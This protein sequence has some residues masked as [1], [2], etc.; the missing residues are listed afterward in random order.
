MGIHPFLT[1]RRLPT[2]DPRVGPSKGEEGMNV[3]ARRQ[4]RIAGRLRTGAL[5]FGLARKALL[6]T[7]ISVA[8]M[9]FGASA[10]SA[11]TQ[12]YGFDGSA[13]GTQV[14]VGSTVQSGR[15]A[16]VTLGC[17]PTPGV[18]NT[19]TAASVDVPGLQ[20]GTIDTS[21]ASET[22]PTGV[23][24]T[25]SATTQTVSVL[26]GLITA[27]AIDSESTTSYNTTT[28]SFAVSS[29]GT[30][31]VALSVNG[32]PIGSPGPNT[33]VT[34]PGVG[35][36]IFNQQTSHIGTTSARLTVI[37]IHV[38]VTLS[39]PLAPKGTQIYVSDA[40]S[41]L[42]PPVTGVLHGLAY[43]TSANL[44]SG[45]VIAGRSFPEYM[46]CL[47]TNG[48][49][50][51]NSGAS[52]SI[53]SIL[54]SGTITDTANGTDNSTQLSGEMTSTVQD[55]DLLGGA[56]TAS[57]VTA[58]VTANGNPPTLGDNSSFL[59]LDVEGHAVSGTPPANTKETLPGIGTL[60]LHKVVETATSIKVIMIQ[61][62]VTAPSN[63][64]VGTT[65]NVG[66]AQVGIS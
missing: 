22:I 32:V 16:Y 66:Y 14:L 9:A 37:G 3:G 13:F 56:V 62:V 47:G 2:R 38:V 42:T 61:I 15:S 55:L 4:R 57:A 34:L 59:D 49:T 36:V 29:A 12:E 19:N 48:V 45:T 28:H 63:P 26:G 52:V 6:L 31:F 1:M 33:K 18:T 5:P 39:T 27:S 43:G 24:S 50:L 25:S 20:T 11:S 60:W 7:G 65:I 41:S 17:D 51:T 40:S 30:S 35:Y 44:A 53:P 21:T 64:L 54:G 10:A 8:V 58:D 46:P 23:E